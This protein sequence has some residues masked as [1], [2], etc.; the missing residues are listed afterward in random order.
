MM[1]PRFRQHGKGQA[2]VDVCRL[3]LIMTMVDQGGTGHSEKKST[4]PR[5]S[6]LRQDWKHSLRTAFFVAFAHHSCHRFF[7]SCPTAGL[8]TAECAPCRDFACQRTCCLPQSCHLCHSSQSL[9]LKKKTR[10]PATHG[11]CPSF[12]S[13]SASIGARSALMPAGCLQPAPH[14]CAQ[15]MR[16]PPSKNCLGGII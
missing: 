10:P 6:V 4:L 8:S 13:V 15:R 2:G 7:H 9:S 5:P 16:D 14:L 11:H 12:F 1:I 3:S